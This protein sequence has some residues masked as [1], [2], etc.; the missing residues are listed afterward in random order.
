M[1]LLSVTGSTSSSPGARTVSGTT[2]VMF[3]T[4]SPVVKLPTPEV[5]KPPTA[6]TSD[7]PRG[8]R[9][10][11]VRLTR[12]QLR[13]TV[14]VTV[15]NRPVPDPTAGFRAVW[16]ATMIT[17]SYSTH[18]S[19]RVSPARRTTTIEDPWEPSSASTDRMPSLPRGVDVP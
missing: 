15:S 1:S 2:D 14:E 7:R 5:G 13:V 11:G 10:I 18:R 9:D 16:M 3:A 6:R 12:L 8:G 17:T 19:D 4:G